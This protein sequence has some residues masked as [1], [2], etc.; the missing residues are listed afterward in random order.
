M[1]WLP[2]RSTL[3]PYTTIFRSESFKFG[4]MSQK[5]VFTVHRLSNSKSCDKLRLG[6]AS[7]DLMAVSYLECGQASFLKSS[8]S[9]KI[10]NSAS[11]HKS[12]F[13]PCTVCQIQKVVTNSDWV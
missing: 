4:L 10:S 6:I 7:H 3:F 11:C 1:I 9:V 8:L 13:L 5:Y 12:M 2:T